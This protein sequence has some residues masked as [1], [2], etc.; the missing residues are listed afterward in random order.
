MFILSLAWPFLS[1]S[2][3][4]SC[5]GT[6]WSWRPQVALSVSILVSLTVFFLLLAE[7]I[8]STSLVVPLL[9]KYL[10]FTMIL[11]TLSICV[12]VVVLNVHF[13]SP[14]T[15]K[16][17]PWV[18]RV[19]IHILPRLLLMRRPPYSGN[20]SDLSDETR[21]ASDYHHK[22]HH[23]CSAPYFPNEELDAFPPDNHLRGTYLG[24]GQSHRH[25]K[26]TQVHPAEKSNRIVVRTCNA[27]EIRDFG[28]QTINPSGMCH[29]FN[30]FRYNISRSSV[31]ASANHIWYLCCDWEDI[32]NS[33][34]RALHSS[35]VFDIDIHWRREKSVYPSSLSWIHRPS[36]SIPCSTPSIWR[37]KIDRSG[38]NKNEV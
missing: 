4:G 15:H 10:L 29:C 16:M 37:I 8:P 23:H 19:F 22:P 1:G 32:E 6:T 34:E 12:S 26:T 30:S 28:G 2:C 9:G 35:C 13:R 24:H 17:A 36:F 11:V 3:N 20:P 21:A 25:H 31:I 5:I 38:R 27:T 18:K 7:I 14:A 33:F